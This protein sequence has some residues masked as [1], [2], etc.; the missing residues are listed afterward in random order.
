MALKAEIDAIWNDRSLPAQE[1]M[2]KINDAKTDAFLPVLQAK[3]GRTLKRG[4]LSVVIER[5][6][7]MSHNGHDWLT[8]H[9]SAERNGVP[10]PVNNPL[11]FRDPPIGNTGDTADLIVWAEQIV[12]DAVKG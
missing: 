12:L 4:D 7:K 10:V 9:I 3:E 2:R 1:R 11:M 6:W 8:V 5:A